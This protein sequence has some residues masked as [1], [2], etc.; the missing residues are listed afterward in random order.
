VLCVHLA[1]S[2]QAYLF[3]EKARDDNAVPHGQA[4]EVE[5]TVLYNIDYLVSLGIYLYLEA[6]SSIIYFFKKSI[7]N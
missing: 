7:L 4:R 5:Y 6:R 3:A 2:Y 1:K